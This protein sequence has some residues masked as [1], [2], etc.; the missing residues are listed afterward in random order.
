MCYSTF[1]IGNAPQLVATFM[2][3]L[4]E[5]G[6]TTACGGNV[7]M[8]EGGY[9]YITPSGLDKAS[10]EAGMVAC[11]RLEDGVCL[12]PDLK[13][14]M[15]S[16]MHRKIYL[17]RPDA[18]AVVHSHPLH[19]SLF[20]ALEEEID[21]RLLAESCCLL[22]RVAKASYALMGSREL[23]MNVASCAAEHDCIL[24]ENH[25]ALTVGKSM[26]QAYERMEVLENAARMTLMTLSAVH[27]RPL[28]TERLEEIR[29]SFS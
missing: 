27:A 8:R 13:V 6:L 1:M 9:M 5:R 15:E 28:C 23:A 22:G 26:L 20:S 19:A 21:T 16:E 29:R 25:G 10:T 4:Y 3:R 2:R 17:C 24:L 11:V 7:S 14:S 12:T 18:V